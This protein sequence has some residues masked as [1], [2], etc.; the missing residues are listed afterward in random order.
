MFRFLKTKLPSLK[1]CMQ[2]FINLSC[3]CCNS[4]KQNISCEILEPASV[5]I[6]VHIRTKKPSSLSPQYSL[7]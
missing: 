7:H 5:Q 1:G 2:D 3:T 6:P 4:F